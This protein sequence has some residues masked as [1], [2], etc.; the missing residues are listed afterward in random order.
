MSIEVGEIWERISDRA[1]YRVAQVFAGGD[2]L[3]LV[4]VSTGRWHRLY[5]TALRAK[6]KQVAQ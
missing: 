6:Y 1:K 3:Y 4:R 2:S 5:A